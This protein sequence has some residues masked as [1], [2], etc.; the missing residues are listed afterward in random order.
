MLL[1]AAG[2]LVVFVLLLWV[3]LRV[4]KAAVRDGIRDANPQRPDRDWAETERQTL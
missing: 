2:A 4:V 1:V 3:G